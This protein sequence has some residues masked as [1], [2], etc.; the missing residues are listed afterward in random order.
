MSY[1]DLGCFGECLVCEL[2]TEG[3]RGLDS[4]LPPD[5]W[6]S[7][8]PL[9]MGGWSPPAPQEPFDPPSTGVEF[10]WP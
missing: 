4:R 7:R 10:D 9:D 1:P 6:D 2:C 3:G 5:W 8:D